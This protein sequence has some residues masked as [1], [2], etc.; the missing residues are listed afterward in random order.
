MK[1]NPNLLLWLRPCAVLGGPECYPSHPAFQD[2]ESLKAGYG[3]GACQWPPASPTLRPTWLY[4]I[5]SERLL[6]KLNH[7][8]LMSLGKSRQGLLQRF[9][10]LS[11][12]GLSWC[13]VFWD[14]LFSWAHG[15]GF[16]QTCSRVWGTKVWLGNLL[17]ESM[18]ERV[19]LIKRQLG[20]EVA[21]VAFSTWVLCTVVTKEWRWQG[22]VAEWVFW[23]L[24]G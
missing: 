15:N 16:L 11:I 17:A 18:D 7:L 10:K 4:F 21:E 3:G 23:G 6:I 8:F 2:A 9:W 5:V 20:G 12:R 13:S 24:S 22:L 14:A 1:I 19:L